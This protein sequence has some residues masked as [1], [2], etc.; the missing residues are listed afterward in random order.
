MKIY[1][2]GL[3]RKEEGLK[4]NIEDIYDGNLYKKLSEKGILIKPCRQ[5]LTFNEHGWRTC[6]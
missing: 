5:Y 6:F 2:I 1:S 3:K 4:D